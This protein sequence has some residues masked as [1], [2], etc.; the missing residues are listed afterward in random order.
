MQKMMLSAVVAASVC[1]GLT[2]R[3]A[4][5]PALKCPVSGQPASKDH[6]VKYKEGQAYFCCDKCPKAFEENTKKFA[7]K[8]NAQLV[9]SGQYKEVKCPLTGN[10]L[11]PAATL[12]VADISVSFCCNDCKAKVAGAK[13]K[14]QVQLVFGD[15]AFGKGFEKAKDTK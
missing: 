2:A 13:E 4:D 12:K 5:E 14:K 11:N 15:K 7:A 3:A 1:L 6:A 8:A 10:D 9:A